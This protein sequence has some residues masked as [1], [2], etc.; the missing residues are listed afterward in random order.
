VDQL[1]Q[2]SRELL[3]Q[4]PCLVMVPR[5]ADQ[6]DMPIVLTA[7]NYLLRLESFDEAAIREFFNAHIGRGPEAVCRP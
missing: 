3:V 1:T 4:N 7:W 2:L 5:P 6:I